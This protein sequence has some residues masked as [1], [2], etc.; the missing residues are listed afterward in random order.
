VQSPLERLILKWEE[1][2]KTMTLSLAALL[3]ALLIFAVQVAPAEA[4]YKG[5]CEH[6]LK[7]ADGARARGD[8]K[9]FNLA[10]KH[11]SGCTGS[12]EYG[13]AIITAIGIGLS[14]Y[15]HGGNGQGQG[16]GHNNH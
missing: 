1:G 12:A 7:A 2:M 8:E 16:H 15:G 4:I 11:Y 13:A 10:M 9:G 6:W 3:A 14:S 5:K